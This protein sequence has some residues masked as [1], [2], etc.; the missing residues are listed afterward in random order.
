MSFVHLLGVGAAGWFLGKA[1]RREMGQQ[2]EIMISPPQP[3]SQPPPPA[4]PP[5]PPPNYIPPSQFTGSLQPELQK[6]LDEL[7]WQAY[8]QDN[9]GTGQ[10]QFQEIMDSYPTTGAGYTQ[11]DIWNYL[12]KYC[13]SVRKTT[14][15]ELK[16]KQ[17]PGR[18]FYPKPK[19]TPEGLGPCPPGYIRLPY[20]PYECVPPVPS[21]SRYM[22]PVRTKASTALPQVSPTGFAPMSTQPV[23]TTTR[24]P[25]PSTVSTPTQVPVAR[26]PAPQPTR[27][28]MTPG[29]QPCPP[30]YV[31][32][33]PGGNCFPSIV[34]GAAGMAPSGGGVPFTM[35]G[36]HLRSQIGQRSFWR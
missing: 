36:I 33:V 5:S 29:E 22:R 24:L 32:F 3:P 12:Q 6:N 2:G 8:L 18:P 4:P 19:P 26:T 35:A 14:L 1:I 21:E 11:D 31:R 27:A 34:T 23:A 16:K 25:G 9:Y 7:C 15:Q 28:A 20:P 13:R 10:T 30:G 17:P